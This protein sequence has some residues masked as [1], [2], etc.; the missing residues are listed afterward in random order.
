MNGSFCGENETLNTGILRK[1]WGYRGITMSDW[2]ATHSTVAP[3]KAGL[4]LEM[5]FPIFRGA[6]LMK[7]VQS[8]TVTEAEI[9]QRAVKM[10]ELRD[11]TKASHGDEAERSEI[12]DETNKIARELAAGGIVLLKNEESTLPLSTSRPINVAVIGEFAHEPVVTGG[13]SA[14]C[15]PQYKQRPCEVLQSAFSEHGNVRYAPGVRT[16]RIIPVA[17]TE[18]LTAADGRHGVEVA[19]FNDDNPDQPILTEFQPS[20]KVFMLGDFKPGLSVPG[21]RL[22][23]TTTLTPATTGPHTLAVRCT[24]AFTLTVDGTPLL[25]NP[26]QPS[27]TTEQFIFNHTLLE[28]RA[29]LLMTAA[30]PYAI[31]LTMHSRTELTVG[32]PTPYAATLGFEEYLHTDAAIQTA[33]DLAATSDVSLIF[34]GRSDQYESEGFDLPDMDMPA[35]QV[36]L[37]RAVAAAGRK[38]VLV[39]HCGNPIDVGPF[40]DEVDAVVLAHFPGQEGARAV[41]DVLTGRVNPSGKL[42]TSWWRILEDA[43]SFGHFPAA[44]GEVDGAVEVRYAEG[45]RV[46][47]RCGDLAARVRWPFGFGLSYTSYEY[48]GLRAVVSEE[49]EA[50]V[51]RC[52]V[53]VTNT[54]QREGK[55]VVQLYVGALDA[56]AVWRPEREL[57][58]FTKVMLQPGERTVVELEVDLKVA[59]SYWDEGVKAWKLEKGRYQVQVGDCQE[60]VVVTMATTWNH[61]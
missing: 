52:S 44:K 56:G 25:H 13:G 53:G 45:I 54:G 1:T 33:A 61:L 50:A 28:T 55:E 34:C 47:Y 17:P 14:S 37:I 26:T 58:A 16:R 41:V 2:F 11:R 51:L 4:D 15:K 8:G 6:R 21:S 32:E 18:Q 43:P 10:L 23:L 40:I 9:D 19:Y 30:Q 7:E 60:Q 35:G 46:G 12:S 22:E 48:D 29:V 24:G 3:I 49:V 36:E 5:P 39:L 31:H 20:A 42:A 59:C 27:I 38:T 57:K